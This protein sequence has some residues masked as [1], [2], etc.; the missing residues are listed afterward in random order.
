METTQEM[1]MD[2]ANQSLEIRRAGYPND[3]CVKTNAEWVTAIN[4]PM[5]FVRK[6]SS[7]QE[8]ADRIASARGSGCNYRLCAKKISEGVYELA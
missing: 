7:Q 6:L 4:A 1:N 2:F 3:T 5:S 8:L